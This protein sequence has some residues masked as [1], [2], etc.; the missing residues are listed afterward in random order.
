MLSALAGTSGIGHD[1]VMSRPLKIV[2]A[3][4]MLVAALLGLAGALSQIVLTYYLPTA[5]GSA[6]EHTTFFGPAVVAAVVAGLLVV[7]LIVHLVRA[8][9]S[10]QRGWEW[11][12]AG[13]LAVVALALPVLVST[14]QRPVF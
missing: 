3:S 5:Q 2:L 8:L 14:V 10:P 13:V 12:V 11:A 6:T 7:V 1:V 4:L 9:R